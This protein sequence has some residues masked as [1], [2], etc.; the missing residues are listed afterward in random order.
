MEKIMITVSVA[1]IIS[2]YRKF[3]FSEY[4]QLNYTV[5]IS[6]IYLWNHEEMR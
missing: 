6:L 4:G 2:Y 3:S 1:E 5:Q